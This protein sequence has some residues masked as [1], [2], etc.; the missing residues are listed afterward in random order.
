MKLIATI[1]ALAATSVAAYPV[2]AP[3]EEVTVQRNIKIEFDGGFNGLCDRAVMADINGLVMETLNA[4]MK[5]Q[6]PNSLQYET[7]II[8]SEQLSATKANDAGRAL[9]WENW[10]W[11]SRLFLNLFSRS[12]QIANETN[13]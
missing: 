13:L 1:L 12:N 2:H 11:V 10:D 9:Y 6:D 5:D 8:D 7:I 3:V 4:G